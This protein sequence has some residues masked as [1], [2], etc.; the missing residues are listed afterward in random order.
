MIHTTEPYIY[1]ELLKDEEAVERKKKELADEM[2]EYK[3][4]R[5]QLKKAVDDILAGGRITLKWHM[6]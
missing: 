5:E 4:Y 1:G 6:D 2:R 3:E